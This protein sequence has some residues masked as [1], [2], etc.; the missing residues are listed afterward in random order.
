MF[1]SHP[2]TYVAL[3]GLMCGEED[4]EGNDD[5]EEQG[6]NG[7]KADLQGGPAGLFSRLGGVGLCHSQ[8]SCFSCHLYQLTWP[9]REMENELITICQADTSKSAS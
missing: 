4:D 5:D 8:V 6:D 7:D 2:L 1:F 3:T 9:K